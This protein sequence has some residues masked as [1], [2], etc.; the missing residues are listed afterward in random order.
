VIDNAVDQLREIRPDLDVAEYLQALADIRTKGYAVSMNERG[1]GAASI[2]APIFDAAGNVLGSISSSGP[3][4]R[5]GE[6]GHED[7]VRLVME[8]ARAITTDLA[9]QRR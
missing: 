9:Q 1:T 2:A 5:Y 6:E 3:V 8:A 4:F 7:H